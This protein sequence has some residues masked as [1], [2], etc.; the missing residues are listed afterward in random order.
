MIELTVIKN[1]MNKSNNIKT[2]KDVAI[3]VKDLDKSFWIPDEKVTSFKSYFLNPFR[4]FKQKGKRFDALSDINFTINK[5][6]FVGVIG[7]NGSG[8]STLLKT[9]ASI[10]APDKGTIR[11]NGHMVPFLELGVGFNPELSARENVYLNGTILGMTRKYLNKKFDEIIDFAEIREFVNTPVKNFSSGMMVRL[12]FAIAVQSDADIYLLDEVFGVGDVN[13][14][15]KSYQ[16]FEEFKKQKKTIILVSHALDD[17]QNNAS[18]VIYVKGGR[19]EE[20]GEPV[21]VIGKYNQDNL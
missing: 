12:A 10:Y 13:F 19:I 17:I 16:K 2:K 6:E 1:N 9:L 4:M 5:G 21:H 14:R 18:R 11:I 3:E 20:D 15:K 8:K 7:R